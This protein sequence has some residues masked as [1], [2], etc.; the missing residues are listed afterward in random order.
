MV[1]A[2]TWNK[3]ST[4]WRLLFSD[5]RVSRA[6]ADKVNVRFFQSQSFLHLA[7]GLHHAFIVHI[8]LVA[9]A[10]PF[11][12]DGRGNLPINNL[13]EATAAPFTATAAVELP[14]PPPHAPVAISSEQCAETLSVILY[15]CPT[16]VTC[17]NRD[18]VETALYDPGGAVSTT[19]DLFS[20][21]CGEI[22]LCNA[23]KDLIHQKERAILKNKHRLLM[24]GASSS[25]IDLVDP[26]EPHCLFSL[27]IIQHKPSNDM[28][29]LRSIV[30]NMF[31]VFCLFVGIV[32]GLEISTPI[33]TSDTHTCLHRFGRNRRRKRR[34]HTARCRRFLQSCCWRWR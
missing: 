20:V 11:A 4:V 6:G 10:D 32:S 15:H 34:R 24:E 31:F 5:A 25:I 14:P 26:G 16:A 9:G 28:R 27:R 33:H 7:I 12:Y 13:C 18:K 23:L 1:Y 3:A 30:Y 8:L 17:P 29:D 19:V 21:Q 22:S 2:I